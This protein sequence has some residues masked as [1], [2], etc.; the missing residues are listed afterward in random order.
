MPARRRNLINTVAHTAHELR[1]TGR[2]KSDRL[3][4]VASL[5]GALPP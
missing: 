2:V 1:L 3:L 4:R 5:G